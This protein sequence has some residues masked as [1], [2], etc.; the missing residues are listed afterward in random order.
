[1]GTSLADREWWQTA[2]SWLAAGVQVSSPI[3][4]SVWAPQHVAGAMA[5]V[6]LVILYRYFLASSMVR[7]PIAGVFLSFTLGTRAPIFLACSI[8]ALVW[9]LVSRVEWFRRRLLYPAILLLAIFLVGSWRQ[10]LLG[11]GSSVSLVWSSFRVPLLE[12]YY[13]RHSPKVA[14]SDR[15]LTL[16]AL[17]AIAAW[18][19]LI[20]MGIPFVL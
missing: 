3:T 10:I 20:E 6:L 14:A 1:M 4:L 8:A 19:L 15:G 9:V 16:L 2:V 5:F 18:V 13:G 17:P 12:T 7:A 11:L